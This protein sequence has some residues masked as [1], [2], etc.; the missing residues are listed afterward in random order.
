MVEGLGDAA[1]RA[2]PRACR[3]PRRT[4]PG[5]GRRTQCRTRRARSAPQQPAPA[6][7]PASTAW[8]GAP[9][10][11]LAAAAAWSAAPKRLGRRRRSVRRRAARHVH[12]V[13]VQVG[14]VRLPRL[15]PLASVVAVLQVI[16]E[17]E[18]DLVARLQDEAW[19]AER[20]C[21]AV[22]LGFRR[23]LREFCS[24]RM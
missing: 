16:D 1:R 22:F 18:L 3:T 5:P 7:T 4:G 17:R 11:A 10:P 20:A 6:R 14:R 21:V 2:R 23:F 8:R 13:Q 19:A 12:A 9:E 15:I 24:R